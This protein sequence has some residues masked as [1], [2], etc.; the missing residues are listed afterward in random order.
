MSAGRQNL[1]SAV[2]IR[3]TP[4]IVLGRGCGLLVYTVLARHHGLSRETAPLFYAWALMQALS[5]IVVSGVEFAFTPIYLQSIG[6]PDGVRQMLTI[7][8]RALFGFALALAAVAAASHLVLPSISAFPSEVITQISRLL[9]AFIPSQLLLTLAGAARAITNAKCQYVRSASSVLMDGVA[10]LSGSALLQPVLGLYAVPTAA[11]IAALTSLAVLASGARVISPEPGRPSQAPNAHG[12]FLIAQIVATSIVAVN[13]VIDQ[14]FASFL[15]DEAVTIIS[16]ASRIFLVPV[17]VVIAGILPIF[18]SELSRR[19]ADGDTHGFEQY[20]YRYLRIT[21][22]TSL[23]VTIPAVFCADSITGLVLLDARVKPVELG[24]VTDACRILFI[25][26]LP[27]VAMN[28]LA[29]VHIARL[30]LGAIWSGALATTLFKIG[31]NTLL[32][33]RLGVSGIALATALSYALV[34]CLLLLMALRRNA[35]AEIAVSGIAVP[36]T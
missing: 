33:R 5:L 12:K 27:Y 24:R 4:L 16:Y 10:F 8:R 6:A 29:R 31:F 3:T 17:G 2:A 26:T 20:A 7:L 18:L 13:P 21:A 32:Y 25:G 19:Q 1:L 30:D 9:W 28:L 15:D 22:L 34:A 11:A 36:L 14:L 23:A 35:T